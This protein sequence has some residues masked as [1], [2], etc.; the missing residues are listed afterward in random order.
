VGASSPGI[1]TV[2]TWGFLLLIVGEAVIGLITGFF[3]SLIFNA[4]AA[5]GQ[6]FSQQM[7]FGMMESY[8]PLS[9]VENPLMGQYLNLVAMLVFL[10]TGG[11]TELF[12][13]GFQRSLQ[14]ISVSALASGR[15]SIISLLTGGLTRLF[16]DAI[17]ISMPILGTLFLIS[18]STGLLSK[19][20]PQINLLSEGFPIA[21]IVAFVLIMATMPFMTEAFSRVIQD[22]FESIES[23]YVRIG[24][25]I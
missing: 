6:F 16:L 2:F 5:A 23:L 12:L 11:F 13:G 10:T 17:I 9:Q 22:G 4:F 21:I 19:A 18:I 3:I 25:G 15:E 8:D 1:G 7:G 20:A 24:G 14:A